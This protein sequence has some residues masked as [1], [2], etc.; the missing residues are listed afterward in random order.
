MGRAYRP[1]GPARPG[2]RPM[3]DDLAWYEG[4]YPDQDE[5]APGPRRRGNARSFLPSADEP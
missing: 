5:R 4:R 1:E 2:E 3:M